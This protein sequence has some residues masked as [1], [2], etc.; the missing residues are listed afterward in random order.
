M[1]ALR[2]AGLRMVH[3][4]RDH[5]RMWPKTITDALCAYWVYQGMG[6]KARSQWQRDPRAAALERAQRAGIDALPELRQCIYRAV[7]AASPTDAHSPFQT[8]LS[9]DWHYQLPFEPPFLVPD[10]RTRKRLVPKD[11][12][13]RVIDHGRNPPQ[14]ETID[15]RQI[16]WLR[17]ASPSGEARAA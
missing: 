7:M 8:G 4:Q 15:A 17:D 12:A 13:M 1:A 2:N 16:V 3:S 5:S 10:C 9:L 11:D 6:N 14:S